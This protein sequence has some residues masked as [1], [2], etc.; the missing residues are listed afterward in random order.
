MYDLAVLRRQISEWE[1]NGEWRDH[2]AWR[3]SRNGVLEYFPSRSEI[4]AKAALLR[5]R[6]NRNGA[7][8]R[9]PRGGRFAVATTAGV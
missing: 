3:R 1:R 2:G 5:S 6:E 4:R 8:A 9:A 7:H